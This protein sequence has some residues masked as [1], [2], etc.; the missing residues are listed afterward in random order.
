MQP[1]DK[2][3]F[4]CITTRPPGAGASCGHSGSRSLMDRLQLALMEHDLSNRVRVNGC[5]CLGPCEQGANMV[6]YPDGVFYRHVTE[7]DLEE[8]VTEHLLCGR[9]V[10][11]LV[12]AQPNPEAARS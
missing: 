11:R 3:V 5:T 1:T 9:P 12:L 6:V 8:I 7:A 10:Q 2:H 4:V